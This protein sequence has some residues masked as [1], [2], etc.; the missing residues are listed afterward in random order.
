MAEITNLN[1]FR[2]AKAR[3]QKEITAANNRVLFGTPKTLKQKAKA[4]T[5]LEKKQLDSK[6]I[7]CEPK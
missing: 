1:K 7:D 2:K 4:Q 6:K 5:I 3:A